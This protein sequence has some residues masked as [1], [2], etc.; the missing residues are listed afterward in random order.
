MKIT[1]IETLVL[2]KK[3]VQVPK[4]HSK[5]SVELSEPGKLSFQSIFKDPTLFSWVLSSSTMINILEEIRKKLFLVVEN[6]KLSIP[7][8]KFITTVMLAQIK[9]IVKMGSYM[10]QIQLKPVGSLKKM[11]KKDGSN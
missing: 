9:K 11:M 1:N 8:A 4:F 7:K 5:Y 2:N 6:Y 3:M 10:T